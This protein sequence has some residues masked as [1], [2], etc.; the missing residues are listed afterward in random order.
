M[1]TE[2]EK[3]IN[4]EFYQALDPEIRAM[5]KKARVLTKEYNNTTL[6][7][8]KE[9][10]LILKELLGSCSDMT[11]IETGFTCDFG[12]NIYFEG[13]AVLNFDVLMLDSAP[14]RLGENIFIG[15]R[16]CI[17]T[18][19]HAID[20]V[21]RLK[22]EAIAKPVT[23]GKNVWIGGSSVILPGVTIGDNVVVGAGSVV[24]KDIPAN[25]VIGGNPAKVIRTIEVNKK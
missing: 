2:F 12:K 13:M 18:A 4:G 15:P 8:S 25:V 7:D 10:L 19:G 6:E 11:F 22:P 9:R 24:T 23:I 14:I 21:E 3:M 1:K 17:Y 5:Q 16:V 20:P